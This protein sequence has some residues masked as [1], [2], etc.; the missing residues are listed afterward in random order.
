MPLF[1]RNPVNDFKI[2]RIQLRNNELEQKNKGVELE[3]KSKAISS[4][5]KV[6]GEQ[7]LTAKKNLSYTKLLLEAEKLK[8]ENNESSLFLLNTRETKVLESEIKLI[9][10]QEKF[11][12]YYFYLVHLSG[13]LQYSIAE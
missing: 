5:L 8:F 13:D 6:M 10:L 9:D 11:L 12:L 3:N 7:V 4:M 2:A 1:F